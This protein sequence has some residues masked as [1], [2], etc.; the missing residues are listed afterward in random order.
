MLATSGSF[1]S[2][3]RINCQKIFRPSTQKS[4]LL[5][6]A[7]DKEIETHVRSVKKRIGFNGSEES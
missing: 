5:E 1:F 6:L 4:P 3:L 2:G 7:P